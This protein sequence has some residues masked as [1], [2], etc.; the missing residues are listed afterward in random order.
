VTY[1]VLSGCEAFSRCQ[2]PTAIVCATCKSGNTSL[3]DIFH[4]LHGS[5]D[6]KHLEELY[7]VMA[8]TKIAGKTSDSS[9]HKWI[10][11]VDLLAVK[12]SEQEKSRLN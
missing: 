1:N 3:S 6:Q 4:E 11:E 10:S 12:E 9:I 8:C 7:T 2:S 5:D